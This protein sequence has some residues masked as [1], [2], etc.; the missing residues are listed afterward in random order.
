MQALVEAGREDLIGYGPRCLIKPREARGYLNKEHITQNKKGSRNN[1]NKN[2]K[3]RNKIQK[4]ISSRN[5]LKTKE[6]LKIQV[7]KKEKRR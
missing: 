7:D 5:N 1:D 2:T 4:E 6:I 3:Q